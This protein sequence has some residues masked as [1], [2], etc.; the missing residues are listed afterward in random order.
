MQR[1]FSQTG[2]SRAM[3]RFSHVIVPVGQVPSTGKALT[4]NRSPW[5]ASITAVT[6]L[7]KSGAFSAISGGRFFA[8]F[9]AG[10]GS[11]KCRLA[12]AASTA[13]KF[14]RTTSA[15]FFPYV[16]SIARLILSIASSRK[17][18]RD[19]EEAGLHDRVDSSSHPG[20]A[21]D[22]IGINHI[23]LELF[24]GDRLL[25][26]L[27]QMLPDLVFRVGRVEQHDG[28]RR[29]ELEHVELFD[30]LKLMNPDEACLFDQI[31]RAYRAG[32][33]SPALHRLVSQLLLFVNGKVWREAEGG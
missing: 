20:F 7:T 4:G 23:Q 5:L 31:G 28:P 26:F 15:P 22:L 30:K 27:R 1:L 9:I 13:A 12:R 21:R 19:G 25:H 17:N 3:F 16:F 8:P 11:S 33:Q 32:A 6:R 24:L 29:S 18:A 2:I 14:L 10:M